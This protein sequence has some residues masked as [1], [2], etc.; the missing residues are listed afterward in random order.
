MWPHYL[1]RWGP[2]QA[3]PKCATLV[4]GLCWVE[5]HQGLRLKKNFDLL[6]QC[7]KELK[8][9]GLSQEEAITINNSWSRCDREEPSKGFWS[10]SSWNT[11]CTS[12]SF[13]L[14]IHSLKSYQRNTCNSLLKVHIVRERHWMFASIII[15]NAKGSVMQN[16]GLQNYSSSFLTRNF[17]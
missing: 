8:M 12:S 15:L 9:G 14:N 5:H 6:P 17:C 16:L 13:N 1:H 10:K 7:L 4:H 3:T 11:P 2:G